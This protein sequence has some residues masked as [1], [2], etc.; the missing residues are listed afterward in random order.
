MSCH[1]VVYTTT[2]A[3]RAQSGFPV[4][5]PCG[6]TVIPIRVNFF[7]TFSALKASSSHPHYGPVP[8]R[9]RGRESAMNSQQSRQATPCLYKTIERG[10]AINPRRSAMPS[11][12]IALQSTRSVRTKCRQAKGTD[13]FGAF[14][15]D[16]QRRPSRYAVCL[17]SKTR[18]R[19]PNRS[20][21]VL[22][23]R[24][25]NACDRC[26]TTQGKR[27]DRFSYEENDRDSRTSR[28]AT[29]GPH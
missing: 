20:E 19:G 17:C 21:R 6:R 8:V 23:M 3:R 10:V 27:A 13:R 16:I 1:N 12:R 2:F 22:Q 11:H 4:F 29:D 9:I 28:T 5:E 7:P 18:S 24:C 14:E 25:A 26:K 15:T